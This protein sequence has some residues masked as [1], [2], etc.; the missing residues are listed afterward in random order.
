MS[1][2]YSFYSYKSATSPE[3]AVLFIYT[4]PNGATIKERMLYASFSRSMTATAKAEADVKVSKR[5]E[6]SGPEEISESAIRQE[7]DPQPEAQESTAG[8]AVAS[9]GF[10]RPKRPGRR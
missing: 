3:P 9:S 4:C 7:M 8:S 5:M 6:A 1:P 10:A 2:Q